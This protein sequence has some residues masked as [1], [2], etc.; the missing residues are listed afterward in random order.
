MAFGGKSR[1][2]LSGDDSGAVCLWDLKKKARVRHFFHDEPTIQV[3]MTDAEV[4]SLSQSALRIFDLKQST[5]R[6]EIYGGKFTCFAISKDMIALGR[7]DGSISIVDWKH[8]ESMH[9]PSTSKTSRITDLV[10]SPANPNLLAAS[11][12]DGQLIFLDIATGQTIQ[13][14]NVKEEITSLSFVADGIHFALGIEPGRVLIYDLR[15][16][17]QVIA[18]KDFGAPIK[19]LEF[20]PRG[21]VS[22]PSSNGATVVES[23]IILG[24]GEEQSKIATPKIR[25]IPVE[26]QRGEENAAFNRTTTEEVVNNALDQLRDEMESSVRNLHVEMLRQFQ[27]Q[28]DEFA[29]ILSTQMHAMAQIMAENEKLRDEIAIL[30]K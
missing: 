29:H 7:F 25:H 6:H 3:A 22:K 16:P 24:L 30:R 2:V 28:S 17:D 26:P 4:I 27:I 12:Q 11:T 14:I 9:T 19:T 8:P 20:A 18:F 23:N 15:T 10:F 5:L 13:A 1:Y 21:Y